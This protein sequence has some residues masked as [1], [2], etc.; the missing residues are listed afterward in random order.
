MTKMTLL[1]FIR[2]AVLDPG[3]PAEGRFAS[4]QKTWTP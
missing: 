4:I 1:K 2:P 3:P